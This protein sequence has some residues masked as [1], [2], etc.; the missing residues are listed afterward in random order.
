M[1]LYRCTH[2]PFSS[3][4]YDKMLK[5]FDIEHSAD[6]RLTI[7]C[8]VDGCL[9]SYNRVN[10]LRSHIYRKHK[11]LHEILL[12]SDSNCENVDEP[13]IAEDPQFNNE[14][15]IKNGEGVN[16][17][18]DQTNTV[19][20]EHPESSVDFKRYL[21]RHVLKIKEKYNVMDKAVEEI[22]QG[23]ASILKLCI[24][25]T[26]E[27]MKKETDV[28]FP[29]CSLLRAHVE[30]D[31][32][33]KMK[34]Q[35]RKQGYV[36][37]KEITLIG[38]DKIVY[39]PILE[40][41][42]VLLKHDDIK[43]E[44]FSD[45]PKVGDS[46]ESFKDSESFQSNSFF[47]RNKPTLRLKLYTDEFQIVN[48]LG[49]KARA[50]KIC[51]V[52]FSL[53]N[54]PRHLQSKVYTIQLALLCKSQVLKRHGYGVV[55]QKLVEDLKV[56]ET[57]GI[58]IATAHGDVK[59]QGS[60]SVVI[61]DNLGA[62]E[63]GGYLCS[64]AC[65]RA[66]RFCDA[67]KSTR[68]EHFDESLF[69]LC[70]E[71][72]YDAKVAIVEKSP[73]LSGCYGLKESSILNEMQHFHVAVGL[74][75]DV[76]HDLFEGFHF[77]LLEN[78][79]AHCL[80]QKYFTLEMLNAYILEFPYKGGD[81]TNKPS[82]IHPLSSSKVKVKQ[83][84]AQSLCLVRLLPLL[85]G[86]HIPEA[87]IQWQLFIKYLTCLDFIL[88]PKLNKGEIELMGSEIRNFLTDFFASNEHLTV[89]PK[90]HFMIHYASQFK[91]FGPLVSNMT[92]R[93]ESKHSYLKSTMA[94]S[95]NYKNVCLSVAQRHQ[96]H[97]AY[98]HMLDDYLPTNC[99]VFTKHCSEH[100]LTNSEI[101]A[102]EQANFDMSNNKFS[103][104]VS[105]NGITY[106]SDMCVIL[107]FDTDYVFARIR[108]CTL[109][110]G[111]AYLI[112][113]V[114]STVYYESHLNAFILKESC[115]SKVL[116]MTDLVSIFPPPLYECESSEY[117][118]FITIMKHHVPM[119]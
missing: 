98:Q 62:H 29:L 106:N 39:V 81:K 93:Y 52:Y 38:D 87:D 90:A 104:S 59:V 64:F 19:P 8:G 80:N 16:T 28:T 109:H 85:I 15:E 119:H 102:M 56:L 73:E 21:L 37:P 75:S 84:A 45:R 110:N 6:P 111:D 51:A 18:T 48:P 67:T 72:S 76:A 96:Y 27:A 118:D 10:S 94:N 47:S 7:H 12:S 77:V 54:V 95:K 46:I 66:C 79:I 5:H 43:G 2:C 115:N 89:K 41:L 9:M 61:A 83:T 101:N 107:D 40:T 34:Q 99:P 92:L 103:R 44:V 14:F 50:H 97:Q 55:L 23:Y 117:G 42:N 22:V 69:V 33:Y 74:P 53:D 17:S 31:T 24:E 58:S 88:A 57:E 13:L 86:T 113:N 78:L 91:F 26:E 32:I 105:V 100:N 11:T 1:P 49:N 82:V 108:Y 63:I 3:R 4:H 116:Q 71:E 35:F 36:A 70:N 65:N 30:I 112:T 20:L 68:Q 60:I 25:E 114:L